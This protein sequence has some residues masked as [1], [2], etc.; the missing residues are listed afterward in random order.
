M[1]AHDE[2]RRMLA[3]E[4]VLGTADF[5]ERRE[6]ERLLASDAQ[7]RQLVNDWSVRFLEMFGDGEPARVP[8]DVWPRILARLDAEAPDD[9][10][11]PT[12]A[13]TAVSQG[14]G[15]WRPFA[16][17]A[18]LL[19]VAFIGLFVTTLTRMTVPEPESKRYVAV[20]NGDEG[21]PAM[22]VTV[23]TGDETLT[24]NPLEDVE[25][26]GGDLQLW[27]LPVDGSSPRSL[28]LA[29]AAGAIDLPVTVLD[30][31]PSDEMSFAISL[32]PKGGSPTGQPTGP[33]LFT[34]QLLPLPD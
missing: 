26:A 4:Y 3:A 5:L 16:I 20:L 32:E 33:I 30:T 34:G 27:L 18:S 28:G 1:A 2:E 12:A 9:S 6:A 25:V 17:A 22:V 19:L 15:L 31:A 21:Q 11:V 14:P 10:T 24:I 29:S 23:N 7:F 8:G 13:P